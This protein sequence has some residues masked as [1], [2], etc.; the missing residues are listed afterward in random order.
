MTKH[1]TRGQLPSSKKGSPRPQ[2]DKALEMVDAEE[3]NRAIILLKPLARQW[4]NNSDI[5]SGLMDCYQNLEDHLFMWQPVLNLLR[6]APADP[7]HW[8][9]RVVVASN[10][11]LTYTTVRCAS[12]FLER[13]PNDPHCK[14]VKRIQQSAEKAVATRLAYVNIE[15]DMTA[16]DIEATEQT[17]VLLTTGYYAAAEQLIRETLKR[18]P[19]LTTPLGILS[20]VYCAQGK[21]Q[22][23]IQIARQVLEKEPDNIYALAHLTQFLWRSG[24]MAEAENTATRLNQTT[25][26]NIQIYKQLESLSYL[27]QDAA[28]IQ[29]FEQAAPQIKKNTV[30]GDLNARIYHLAAVAYANQGDDKQAMQLWKTALSI[31]KDLQIADNNLANLRKPVGQRVKAFP[32]SVFEWVSSGWADNF[33]E[34]MNT[35]YPGQKALEKAVQNWVKQHSAIEIVL[36]SLF[37]RGDPDGRVW[38]TDIALNAKLPI[39]LDFALGSNGT[40]DNR[41]IAAQKSTDIGLLPR[42]ATVS[43]MVKGKP[44]DVT[45]LPYEIID[46]P[47]VEGMPKAVREIIGQ[48]HELINQEQYVIAETFIRAVIDI[49]PDEPM[50]WNHLGIAI[51]GQNRHNEL[52]KL[53][54]EMYERF[55][56]YLF[57][58]VVI[59]QFLV[60]QKK[61]EAARQTLEPLTTQPQLHLSEYRAL[62]MATIDLLLAEG[63]REAAEQ[64]LRIWE[65]YDDDHAVLKRYKVLVRPPRLSDLWKKT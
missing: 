37:E 38:A 15:P 48:A 21:Y 45:L 27:R 35:A 46:E 1:K 2:I 23:A 57:A 4:P 49:I 22:E 20:L 36:P 44:T 25:G 26:T 17:E 47:M 42:G 55:P 40:D 11:G 5:W 19:G 61:L 43:L 16:A 59:A 8:F 39:L 56:D 65:I 34:L 60:K 41:F 7:A 12:E 33:V 63:K 32:F 53:V 3:W 28:V 30:V 52:E 62:S 31:N 51:Q 50:L 9:N 24:Q 10:I 54:Y 29:L 58:R 13:F 18:S 14:N 64:W 6:L